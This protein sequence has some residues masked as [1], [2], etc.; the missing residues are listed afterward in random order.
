LRFI[1]S[2]AQRNNSLPLM[3]T[4]D[5]TLSAGEIYC[6]QLLLEKRGFPLYV[7]QPQPDFPEG[8]AIGDVGCIT[9]EGIFDFFFNIFLPPKHPIN[10]NRTPENFY[11]IQL[12]FKLEVIHQTFPPG[13]YV[14]SST[15]QKV[16]PSPSLK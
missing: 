12:P 1:Q 15:V 13:C 14:R 3:N 10:A 2:V 8:V 9:E 6:S 7:P 16:D 4:V 11:P 5:E